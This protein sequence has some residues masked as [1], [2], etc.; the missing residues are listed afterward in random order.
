MHTADAGV[1]VRNRQPVA[2]AGFARVLPIGGFPWSPQPTIE[3]AFDA[4]KSSDPDGNDL[5]WCWTFPPFAEPG[6]GCSN[7][8]RYVC[9]TSVSDPCFTRVVP[10]AVPIAFFAEVTAD[11]GVPGLSPT[12]DS[13]QSA[14]A[15]TSVTIAE[16]PLWSEYIQNLIYD[17]VAGYPARHDASRRRQRP[18]SSSGFVSDFRDAAFSPSTDPFVVSL[19]QT[20][21]STLALE[22][23]EWP[24]GTVLH[25]ETV[26]YAPAYFFGTITADVSGRVWIATPADD[27]FSALDIRTWNRVGDALIPEDS[28]TSEPGTGNILLTTDDLGFA[29]LARDVTQGLWRIDPLDMGNPS[30]VDVAV[31]VMAAR[32]RTGELFFSSF[33]SVGRAEPTGTVTLFANGSRS[34]PVLKMAF[35]GTDRLWILSEEELKLLDVPALIATQSIDLATLIALPGV[36]WAPT[37]TGDP[38]TGGCWIELP[39][40]AGTRYV[41]PDG[42][43]VDHAGQ[44]ISTQFA[45]A[46]GSLW[47]YENATLVRGRNTDA[48]DLVRTAEYGEHRS[49]PD[50][51]TG[52]IWLSRLG[53]QQ[54]A[55]DGGVVRSI[56]GWRDGTVDAT[57]KFS[58]WAPVGDGE[59]VWGLEQDVSADT[60]VVL[61]DL[62]SDPPQGTTAFSFPWVYTPYDPLFVA[63]PPVG[64]TVAV[65]TALDTNDDGQV[66]ILRVGPGGVTSSFALPA[67]EYAYGLAVSPRTGAICLTTR[68]RPDDDDVPLDTVRV[69]WSDAAGSQLNLLQAFDPAGGPRTVLS[70]IAP[71][72]A[73]GEACWVLYSD[74]ENNIPC[75]TLTFE[76]SH[77]AGWTIAD[78][79]PVHE[80]IFAGSPLSLQPV[81][82]DEL[83]IST[84]TCSDTADG[85]SFDRALQR[86]RFTSG[87]TSEEVARL[88]NVPGYLVT[89]EASR[90]RL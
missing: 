11:D 38:A 67:G 23:R 43:T 57:L 15:F 1:R 6:P 51:T 35:A 69:Y 31:Y 20:T 58:A 60:R 80:E 32:P 79:T 13:Q 3:V 56:S 24:G 37:L 44:A 50:I 16:P 72:P 49:V 70:A 46:A 34:G 4:S 77:F 45:D 59:H 84:S 39:A 18:L 63:A 30:F 89:T 73:G 87:T 55:A 9:S 12:D 29:W 25:E 78:G 83:W 68:D 76:S 26:P 53:Q 61:L 48:A 75:G 71:A 86:R 85:Y 66:E 17:E 47:F 88:E 42:S 81:S 54:I 74:N 7:P 52:G 90:S 14:P 5:T 2:H 62:T 22:M 27:T 10:A 40:H 33:G 65:W 8:S 82:A 64:A 36:L 19:F 28:F 21:S 41:A